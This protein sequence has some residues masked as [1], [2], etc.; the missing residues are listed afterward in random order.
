[1]VHSHAVHLPLSAL[2]SPCTMCGT[3]VLLEHGLEIKHLRRQTA[4]HDA[5]PPSGLLLRLRARLLYAMEPYDRTIWGTLRDPTCFAINLVFLFPF[6]GVSDTAILLYAL[7]K[8]GTNF[9]TFGL[10]QF[11]ITSKRLQFLTSGLFGS[12]LSTTVH[13]TPQGF[14]P[15]TS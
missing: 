5:E 9:D 11:I 10:T 15:V 6:Y 1:M 12:P 13:F 14:F 4:M 3:G 7:A 2:L 8:L